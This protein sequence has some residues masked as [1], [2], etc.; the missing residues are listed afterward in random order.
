MGSN[1]TTLCGGMPELGK[2]LILPP[3][4][5]LQTDERRV[6]VVVEP[7]LALAPLAA[8]RQTVR[9]LADGEVPSRQA[10]P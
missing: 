10:V 2:L 8:E 5:P 4:T 3:N 1:L 6:W 9:R 7:H